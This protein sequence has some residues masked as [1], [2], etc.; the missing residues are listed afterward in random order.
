M[1][2]HEK[3]PSVDRVPPCPLRVRTA[4]IER[5]PVSFCS[6]PMVGGLFCMEKEDLYDY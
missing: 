2:Q 4:V 1:L 6:I 3:I 5:L